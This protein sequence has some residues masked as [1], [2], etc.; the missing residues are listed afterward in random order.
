MAT[1]FVAAPA[2]E[3]EELG[4]VPHHWRRGAGSRYAC[5]Q[6]PLPRKNR[7]H[8]PAAVDGRSPEETEWAEHYAARL[9]E[10]DF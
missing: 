1:K 9:G 4:W 10:R 7:I 3:L 5:A 8:D 2:P 6:C